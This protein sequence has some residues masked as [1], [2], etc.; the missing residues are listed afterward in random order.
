MKTDII[1]CVEIREAAGWKCGDEYEE[2]VAMGS[3]VSL[4]WKMQY[5]ERD[6]D[7]FG[8]LGNVNA[9]RI[10]PLAL[11]RGLPSGVSHPV[12]LYAERVGGHSHTWFTLDEL[13]SGLE[14][15]EAHVLMDEHPGIREEDVAALQAL[16][17]LKDGPAHLFPTFQESLARIRSR[18]A[19][20]A[21]DCIRCVMWFVDQY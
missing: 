10:P 8:M 19:H 18:H 17:H 11:P 6:D 1:F 20:L 21:L 14:K 13:Y 3:G 7:L 9:G 2:V 15:T 4:V 5:H 12:S 16:L